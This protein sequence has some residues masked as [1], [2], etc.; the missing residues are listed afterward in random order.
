VHR[1]LKGLQKKTLCCIDAT[2]SM[3]N[4]LTQT[5]QTVDKMF[6][7]AKNYLKNNGYDHESFQM[8]F[9][10]YRN[11]DFK[12]DKVLMLSGW[13]SKP[14]N[15]KT[16]LDSVHAE[17]GWGT[18]E[19]VELGLEIASKEAYSKDGLCQVILIGDA[20]ANTR[21]EVAYKRSSNGENYWKTTKMP[22]PTCWE[23]EVPKL[24]SK[25]VPVFS[26]YL[27]NYAKDTFIQ[28]SNQTGGKAESLNVNASDAADNLT[29]VVSSYIVRSSVPK[30]KAEEIVRH[31][32]SNYKSYL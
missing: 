5:K 10:I 25:Q 15:L 32:V 27:N 16:F 24:S 18:N 12:E 13:E 4:L 2:G 14:D 6:R 29:K 17:C 23:D 28:I 8:Q 31:Y 11:Y 22:Y 30:E 26:F 9:C 21:E 19:A 20:G 3:G 1:Y 7:G